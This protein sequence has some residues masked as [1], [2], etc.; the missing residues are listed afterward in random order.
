MPMREE[1]DSTALLSPLFPPL[2]WMRKPHGGRSYD[3]YTN[4]AP[5]FPLAYRP[6]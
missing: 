3:I 4:E 6:G 1:K 5:L 2:A